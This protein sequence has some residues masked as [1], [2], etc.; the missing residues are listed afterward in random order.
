MLPYAC[1]LCNVFH[2]IFLVNWTEA[3]LEFVVEK[4][5]EGVE[6]VDPKR[7]F[8]VFISPEIN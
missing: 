3:M 4:H 8:T 5:K 6:V 2:S 1:F 7:N